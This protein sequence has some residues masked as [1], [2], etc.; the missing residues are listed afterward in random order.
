MGASLLFPRQ[1]GP[2]KE[3]M[4]SGFRRKEAGPLPAVWVL[5]S[6]F[7]IPLVRSP[8]TFWSRPYQRGN[9]WKRVS[10]SSQ[11]R[12]EDVSY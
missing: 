12:E 9:R 8:N 7:F 3:A 4:E 1:R 11:Q 5:G 2:K 6:G 10:S